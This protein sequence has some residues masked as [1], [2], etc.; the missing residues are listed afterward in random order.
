MTSD[1]QER[2]DWAV[3]TCSD[4]GLRRTNAM[5]HLL[6]ELITSKKPKTLADLSESEGLRDLCDRVTV[7]RLLGR[8]VEKK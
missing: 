3:Q 2:L 1:I 6:K 4:R 7:Y 5:R 8:L